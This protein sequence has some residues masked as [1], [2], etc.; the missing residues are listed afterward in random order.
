MSFVVG[1]KIG[2]TKENKTL[3]DLK[4]QYNIIIYYII[5]IYINNTRDRVGNK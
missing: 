1:E 5:Y 4:Q 3:Y 2:I